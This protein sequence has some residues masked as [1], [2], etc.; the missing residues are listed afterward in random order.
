M[1]LINEIL[2][3]NWLEYCE[4]WKKDGKILNRDLARR[5]RQEREV[6]RLV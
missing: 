1:F 4:K 5:E 2:D 3:G 6:I